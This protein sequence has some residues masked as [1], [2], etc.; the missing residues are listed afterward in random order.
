MSWETEFDNWTSEYMPD[1]RILCN[2][3]IIIHNSFSIGGPAK[4]MALPERR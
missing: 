2:E 4:M 1:L 3:P